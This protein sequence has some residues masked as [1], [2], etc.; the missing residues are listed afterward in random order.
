MILVFFQVIQIQNFI[1]RE[2]NEFIELFELKKYSE[3]YTF[4]QEHKTIKEIYQNQ[5]IIAIKNLIMV[6]SKY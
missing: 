5:D 4:S 1:E 2:V 6:L 3:K